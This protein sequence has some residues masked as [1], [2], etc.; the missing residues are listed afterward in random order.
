M[1][2]PLGILAASGAGGGGSFESI[3]SATSSNT[4]VTFTSIPSTYTHLQIR[5]IFTS[6]GASMPMRFNSDTG[7]NYSNHTLYGDSSSAGAEGNANT[8]R[9]LS[10]N[11]FYGGFPSSDYPG[12][13]II[14]IH[15]YASTS[16]YK[17]IRVFGGMDNNGGTAPYIALGSGSW[18]NTNAINSITFAGNS[19]GTFAL[20]GIKGA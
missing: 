6:G 19:T 16:T 3:A 7:S 12:V 18:R 15:N 17:T 11:Y 9:L 4:T 20:Y 2:I 14:D 8:D 13:F 10:N 5:A 1:L